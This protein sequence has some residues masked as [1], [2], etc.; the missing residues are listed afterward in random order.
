MNRTTYGVCSLTA[1]LSLVACFPKDQLVGY[2]YP[3]DTERIAV[4]EQCGSELEQCIKYLDRNND[5]KY[6]RE[7]DEPVSTDL[8]PG[9]LGK[10]CR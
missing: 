7:I 5:G 1:T 3:K 10:P 8:V 9:L 2:Y 4:R 6:E